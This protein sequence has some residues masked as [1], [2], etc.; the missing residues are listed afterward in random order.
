MKWPICSMSAYRWWR[1]CASASCRKLIRGKLA[2]MGLQD[3]DHVLMLGLSGRKAVRLH[4]L[5][6]HRLRRIHLGRILRI[7]GVQDGILP[8]PVPILAVLIDE[9]DSRRAPLGGRLWSMESCIHACSEPITRYLLALSC[10]TRFDQAL[11]RLLSGKSFK[12][13]L[14]YRMIATVEDVSP[15]VF[16]PFF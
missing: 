4:H 8:M 1:A 6:R 16:N 3:M 7:H 15:A 2:K 12:R 14:V 10:G 9:F 13:C 11:T 5:H